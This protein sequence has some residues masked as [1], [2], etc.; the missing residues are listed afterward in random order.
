MRPRYLKRKAKQT[1]NVTVEQLD[2]SG[3]QTPMSPKKIKTAPL[4]A[5]SSLARK[6][7]KAESV[8]TSPSYP[9]GPPMLRS[10]GIQTF[11]GATI[12]LNSLTTDVAHLA[13][14]GEE[15]NKIQPEE[16]GSVYSETLK[17][18]HDTLGEEIPSSSP[19]G[20][21]FS[22]KRR[23]QTEP[24]PLREI[25]STPERPERNKKSPG[26]SGKRASSPLFIEDNTEEEL[27]LE[28]DEHENGT[29][30]GQPPSDTLS[31]PDQ[32]ARNTQAIFQ[33]SSQ[34]IDFNVPP[35]NEG[36]DDEDAI[37]DP[38]SKPDYES[39]FESD[40]E[41]A[42]IEI[43]DPRPSLPNTQ[44]ILESETQ[45]P[46][47]DLPEPEGGW[48]SVP[49]SS[50]PPMASSPQAE[51]EISQTNIG[52]QVDAWIEA[53]VDKGFSDEQVE[54][55]LKSTSMDTSL[56]DEVLSLMAEKGE[57]PKNMPGV[58]TEADD[59]D[60]GSTDARKIQRSQD[61]H[62]VERW[63]ARFEFLSFYRG[64]N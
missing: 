50:P 11:Q 17:R 38:K 22:P 48:D 33:D 20:P 2:A 1:G 36:W 3:S 31:E 21:A 19:L 14:Q 18:K 62:G 10:P 8:S 49:P 13:A 57:M 43:N 34:E 56:A 42:M 46:D 4:S 9:V 41:S 55:V 15:E 12:I 60:L 27:G 29:L 51:S 40:Y 35:P 58:W 63:N 61:K 23:R 7:P 64:Y 30:L 25:P 37:E 26:P 59:E 16:T 52:A 28:D 53:H 24:K 6:K 47:F 44:A 5:F 45:R 32:R 39:D 54:S